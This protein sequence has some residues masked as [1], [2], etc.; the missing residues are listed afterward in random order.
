[1]NNT[2]RLHSRFVKY[3]IGLTTSLGY[4]DWLLAQYPPNDGQKKRAIKARFLDRINNPARRRNDR[5][6]R[7]YHR[8]CALIP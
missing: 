1:M 2:L 3:Q 5:D 8:T 6:E 4:F 7:H